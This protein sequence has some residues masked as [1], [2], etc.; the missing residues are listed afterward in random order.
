ML[1][2]KGDTITPPLY[3]NATWIQLDERKKQMQ[4]RREILALKHKL[5]ENSV[6]DMNAA[7]RKGVKKAL[8][9]FESKNGMASRRNRELLNNLRDA[10]ENF[11]VR[12]HANASSHTHKHLVEARKEYI[13][14]IEALY[15][16]WKEA[17]IHSG[18]E[19][20]AKLERQKQLTNQRRQVAKEAFEKE[21]QV[22]ETWMP[23]EERSN[24]PQKKRSDEYNCYASSLRSSLF[25]QL[26]FHN[27]RFESS[28]TRRRRTWQSPSYWNTT[29]KW[30]G[31]LGG[32]SWT[33]SRTKS[34]ACF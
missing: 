17:Q 10:K 32:T 13:G 24:E 34:R 7:K 11:A 3:H 5:R 21:Q 31:S 30:R 16:A 1:R 2:Q 29:K 25:A 15:P 28:W 8:D 18:V 22:S 33:R 6:K 20:I 19:E 12:S 27:N 23:S 4:Q 14:K 9:M 26:T